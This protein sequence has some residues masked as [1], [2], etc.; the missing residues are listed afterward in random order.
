MEKRIPFFGIA[1]GLLLAVGCSHK[2]GL[3]DID[4]FSDIPAGAIPE[5]VGNKVGKIQSDQIGNASVDQFFLYQADFIGDSTDL[6]PDSNQRLTRMH[7]AGALESSELFVQPSGQ[8]TLD[9]QRVASVRSFLDSHGVKEVSIEIANPAAIGLQGNLAEASVVGVGGR[10]SGGASSVTG[11]GRLGA[12]N[13]FSR[14]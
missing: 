10:R 13:A 1:L 5:P 8:A 2:H 4:R 12:F 6:S 14:D 11:G 9:E 3:M 7:H